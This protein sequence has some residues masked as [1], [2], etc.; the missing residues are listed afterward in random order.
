MPPPR[1]QRP[2]SAAAIPSRPSNNPA[3]PPKFRISPPAAA[4]R[5]NFSPAKNCPASKPSPTNH[6]YTTQAPPRNR[7]QLED[8]QN[9]GGHAR[10][11]RRLHAAR[12]QRDALRHRDRAAFHVH[13]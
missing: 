8:A 10:L 4:R 5:S 9:A 3:S 13:L 11:L 7:R 2:S 1:A 12:R 6:D